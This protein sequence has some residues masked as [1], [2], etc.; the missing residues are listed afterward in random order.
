M[1]R[2]KPSK[3]DDTYGQMWRVVDGAVAECFRAHPDYLPKG[4]NKR[5]IRASL[6]KRVTGAVLG[7]AVQAAKARSV[8]LR[9]AGETASE[10]SA[11][12]GLGLGRVDQ[13]SRPRIT[14]VEGQGAVHDAPCYLERRCQPHQHED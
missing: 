10:A 3:P 2:I 11:L 9:T 6:V 12:R 5:T 8:R 1:T 4:E 14:G 7:F 13:A